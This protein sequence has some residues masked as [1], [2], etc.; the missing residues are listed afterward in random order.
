MRNAGLRGVERRDPDRSRKPGLRARPVAS[1]AGFG[2][3]L[4]GFKQEAAA[5]GIS[6]QTIAAAL[7]GVTYDPAVIA[8]DRGQVGVRA[9]LPAILR[10]HGQR[11]PAA[12]RVGAAQEE[13]RHLRQDPAAIRRAGSGARRL[14]GAGDRFRQGDGQYGDA[15][16][17]RHARL[18]LPPARRVQGSSSS[19]RFASSSAAISARRRCAGRGRAR[20]ASFSSC[21][22]SITNMPSTSTATASA[23]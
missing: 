5:Q 16:L 11:Q 20:S 1:P 3:W 14:L 10:P 13:R 18:R 2:R 23:T 21:R 17:A 22:A 8:K 9:D 4:Q 19:M 12:G 15:P 6:P 7:D